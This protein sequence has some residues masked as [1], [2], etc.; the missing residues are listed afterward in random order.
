MA[1][2]A[3]PAVPATVNL[4]RPAA[5]SWITWPQPSR[6]TFLYVVAAIVAVGAL[7][8]GWPTNTGSA[9]QSSFTLQ[10]S[11][12]RKD[13]LQAM[14]DGCFRLFNISGNGTQ[15][16]IEDELEVLLKQKQIEYHPD[17]CFYP[18]PTLL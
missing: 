4:P 11:Q 9:G 14:A 12:R 2:S 10:L 3:H 15:E 5:T 16:D 6:Q 17:V 1:S 8:G 18:R 7:Y 13:E